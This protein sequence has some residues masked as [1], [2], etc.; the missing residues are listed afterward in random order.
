MERQE[1]YRNSE[2]IEK[3]GQRIREIRLSKSISQQHLADLCNLELSQIN[4]IE[5]GK[6]NTSVSHLFLIA[7]KL[8]VK[9][10]ELIDFDSK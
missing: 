8:G 3:L 2:V 4:R 6:V 9:P 1:Q 5:L 7:E 10:T